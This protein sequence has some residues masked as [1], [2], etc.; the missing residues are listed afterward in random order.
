MSYK[1]QTT[2][3]TTMGLFFVLLESAIV[4][5][6]LIFTLYPVSFTELDNQISVHLLQNY[7]QRVVKGGLHFCC[8]A[9]EHKTA[10]LGTDNPQLLASFNEFNMHQTRPFEKSS[11]SITP[12]GKRTSPENQF[13]YNSYCQGLAKVRPALTL[14]KY[15]CQKYF[16]KSNGVCWY[17]YCNFNSDHKELFLSIFRPH[18]S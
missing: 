14:F 18:I 6:L 12:N 3:K 9:E 8:G 7:A 13:S 1:H 15:L 4:L 17:F 5:K 16:R 10:S 2:E 11:T